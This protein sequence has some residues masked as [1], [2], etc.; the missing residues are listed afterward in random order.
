MKMVIVVFMVL[1]MTKTFSSN[2]LTEK[3][4]GSS[5]IGSFLELVILLD[6][7]YAFPPVFSQSF[8]SIAIKFV[9]SHLGSTCISTHETC[10]SVV[11]ELIFAHEN[12]T[13]INQHHPIALVGADCVILNIDY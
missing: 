2:K 9:D 11:L 8:N 7:L 12:L 6:I 13:V 3:S 1:I 5:D 10:L 4:A